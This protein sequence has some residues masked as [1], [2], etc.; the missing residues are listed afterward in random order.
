MNLKCTYFLQ[1]QV[2]RFKHQLEK[3]FLVFVFVLVV[4]FN[5]FDL[6]IH[7]SDKRDIAGTVVDAS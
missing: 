2:N 4:K 6:A 1:L 7:T 3:D 5:W